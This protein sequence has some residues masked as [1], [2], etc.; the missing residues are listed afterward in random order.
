[1]KQFFSVLL[2]FLFS[3]TRIA[4]QDRNAGLKGSVTDEQGKPLESATVSLL[5]AKD[6]ALVKVA[7]S[8]KQGH[9][10]FEKLVTGKYLIRVSAI[11]FQPFQ[12]TLI[13]LG[14][15][16]SPQELPA[17]TMKA[18]SKS[19]S[20]VTVV[21]RKP[22]IENKIDR[23]V[24]NV[25]A[26]PTNAGSTAMEV[27]EKSPGISVNNDGVVS[28]KGKQGVIVMMDGKPTYLSPADLANLLRNLPASAID[29]I[30]IMP[31][32]PA[33]FD[34]S[35]NSG[36]INIKTKKSRADGFNGSLSTGGTLGWYKR[37][38]S[39]LAPFKQTTSVNFNYR[40]GK[41]NLFGNFN[42][43]YREGKNEL[44]LVRNFYEKN[45]N[46]NSVSSSV[47]ESNF[48]NNN[49]TLKVGLDY[50]ID[51]KN[52]IGMVVNGFAFF[53]FPQ[54]Q[55]TQSILDVDGMPLSILKS[56]SSSRLRFYNYSTN[57]NY[58][59]SFDSAGR[60]LT[61]DFDYLG[62]NNS[63]RS[64]LITDVYNSGGT[65]LGGLTL[66]GDIPGVI[67]I[68]SFKSDYVHPLKDNMRFEAGFKTSFVSND[69]EIVYDRD[70]NGTWVK[71]DRSNHFIYREN[72]N[73]AYASV[74]KKWNKW[75]AQ[76]GLRLENTIAKG[77]QVTTDS[78]FKRNYTS[79]F[80][81]AFLNYELSKAHS[82]TLS[83]GRR[84][85]RPNYQDLNPFIWFLDSLTFRK[86]NP[87][88]LPQYSHNIELRHTLLGKFTT[89]LNYTL[90]NDVISQIMK[91]NTDK[92]ET[93]LTVDNVAQSKN[94]GIAINAPVNPAKW[95]NL[96]IFFNLY[97]NQFTGSYYNSYTGK[98][99]PIDLNYT[100]YMANVTNMFTFK[101]GWTAEVSGFY[102]ARGLDQLGISEPM[103]FLNLGAQKQVLKGKGT[104]RMNLRDP[105][106][107]Q[108]FK[109]STRYSDIDVRVAN[110]WD[111]RSLTLTFS[112]RFGK[113]TVA[114]ARKRN[115]SVE[116]QNRVGQGQ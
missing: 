24:V 74:N 17:Y 96:N 12:S 93:Y 20:E 50:Y 104:L 87:F 38:N 62:Y 19:L 95:W 1:M 98:N 39:Y 33:R 110:T 44:S 37:G 89:T 114:Q 84:I 101:Q 102:R 111:N 29:Q 59:H 41:V 43:N 100:S 113:N 107:W 3:I 7:V 60:E 67:D 35:G 51:K 57:L 18:G 48:R 77:N 81:T 109:G 15:G 56:N 75:S 105:F 27:L 6:S 63:N 108:R 45:G 88:I 73:A 76:A 115:N 36:V 97:N 22:L 80:P 34:A 54:T 52:V 116:E 21:A 46:L 92:R 28:L 9:F 61:M 99:D 85:D 70:N 66:R 23:T 78:T 32:P 40:K 71:D 72:I 25:E 10:E 26:A 79:L 8:T 42:Y 55:G 4:A 58:K 91:Q 103:Y 13:D 69:N 5:R 14:T 112:Y 83:Y 49:Y 16:G 53:G 11:G 106:H 68:Y 64:L 65:K 30:E 90:T 94:I 86:G 31:N 82:L 47:N 2:L